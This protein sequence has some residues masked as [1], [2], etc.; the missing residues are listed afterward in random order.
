MTCAEVVQWLEANASEK[1]LSGMARYG[2]EA[3]QPLGVT[4]GQLL[5]LKKKLGKS[6]ALSQALWAT[7]IYEA[8]L[9]AS[10]VGEPDKVT[11]EQMDAW[12]ASF[13]NWADCDTVCFNLFDR[14]PAR[15]AK[16]HQWAVADATYVKRA[17]FALMA[18]LVAHDKTASE[19]QFLALLPLIEQGAVDERPIVGKGVSWALRTVGKATPARN[20]GAVDVARRL[21]DSSNSVARAVGKEALR[22]LSSA[23]VQTKFKPAKST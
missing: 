9:L 11:S 7:G 3:K 22:E 4:M 14:A 20:A 12:A 5:T 21:A 19:E 6:H 16:A 15:W 10:M 2:I 1:T 8:R 13:E 23:K 18:C 17:G